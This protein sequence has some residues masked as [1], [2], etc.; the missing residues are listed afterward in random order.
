M[1]NLVFCSIVLFSISAFAQ[2]PAA[3]PT[4]ESQ[5]KEKSEDVKRPTTDSTESESTKEESE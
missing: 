1:K 4:T 5:I 3:V 2:Q